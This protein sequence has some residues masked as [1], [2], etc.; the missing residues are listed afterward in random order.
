[1]L[2]ELI[3]SLGKQFSLPRRSALH[4]ALSLLLAVAWTPLSHCFKD[5]PGPLVGNT[6]HSKQG[7]ELPPHSIPTAR[8]VGELREHLQSN[9]KEL[10]VTKL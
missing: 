6:R 8:A 2:I 3:K 5:R 9:P 1:M 10:I 7:L 4:L